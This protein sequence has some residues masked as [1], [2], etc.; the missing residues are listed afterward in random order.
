MADNKKVINTNLVESMTNS[1]LEFLITRQY[2]NYPR[3]WDVLDLVENANFDLTEVVLFKITEINN[4]SNPNMSLHLYNLYNVL[5]SLQAEQHNVVYLIKGS[6]DKTDIYFGLVSNENS[7]HNIDSTKE[8]ILLNTL[9]ANYPGLQVHNNRKLTPNDV[10]EEIGNFI[11]NSKYVSCLP[12]V[13]SLKREDPTGIFSQGI[14]RIIEAMNGKEYTLLAIAEPVLT[15]KVNELIGIMQNYAS[16][17]HGMVKSNTTTGESN[18]T[19]TATTGSLSA[20]IGAS[21]GIPIL[22][23]QG[24]VGGGVS[25]TRG[26]SRSTFYQNNIEILNKRAEYIETF[27]NKY[28]ERLQKGL[29]YGLWKTGIYLITN[30]IEDQMVGKNVMRSIY[31]GDNSYYEPLRSVELN[32]NA[33]T[34]LKNL[35][36]TR[37]SLLKGE[38]DVYNDDAL[39][40]F[41]DLLNASTTLMNTEELSIIMNMPRKEVRGLPVFSKAAYGRNSNAIVNDKRPT[42]ELGD[43]WHLGSVEGTQVSLDID[44]LTMHTFITGST[45][46]GKTNTIIKMLSYL[47]GLKP[48][49]PFLVIEPT[50][51]E[52]AKKIGGWA[53]V[54]V[55]GTNLSYHPLLRLNPLS[56]PAGIHVLEHIDRLTDILNACWPMYAAMPAIL[57]QALERTYQKMG[58]DLEYSINESTSNKFPNLFD[59]LLSLREVIK[60]SEYSADT[61]SDYTGALITRVQSLTNGL[62]GRILCGDDIDPG[63]MFNQNC[64]IDISRVGSIETKSLLMGIVFMKLNEYLISEERFSGELRHITVLEEA[65]HLLRKTSDVFSAESSNIQ[66]KAVEMITNAIAEMRAFGE[67]F[68]ISDQSPDLLDKAVIRNT[69]TKIILRLPEEMDKQL[70]GRSASLNEEQIHY[71]SKLDTGVACIYQN[72]WTQAVLCNIEEVK[73]EKFT[74]YEH[75]NPTSQTN[76]NR[77]KADLMKLIVH[78]TVPSVFQQELPTM[79]YQELRIWLEQYSLSGH[80]KKVLLDLIEMYSSKVEL[81]TLEVNE[82]TQL[83]HGLYNPSM[84]LSDKMP[85]INTKNADM[86]D[87]VQDYFQKAKSSVVNLVSMP[88]EFYQDRFFEILMIDVAQRHD[89]F[90]DLYSYHKDLS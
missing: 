78:L 58:W 9:K 22:S 44:K 61:K 77:M 82:V 65:H 83:I 68:I 31:S 6:K 62:N 57:K 16:E 3:V 17:I 15:N 75:K 36:N 35:K 29:S 19:F 56:F 10:E 21:I 7:D 69:N 2:A 63:K 74:K 43:L 80:Q 70:V 12:G 25:H 27:C 41:G 84:I 40:P 89:K 4:E 37:L 20:N 26:K 13:P 72:S 23:V 42:L 86:I 87:Q 90:R 18:S 85:E 33:L 50:K 53:G 28:I 11:K 67:G 79:D 47:Q 55:F 34:V 32:S 51:G 49:I 88:N 64:I 60:N 71:L 48:T 73:E 54:S 5:S 38:K 76:D 59:L 14:D 52:Y 30:H 81:N 45:G 66:G 39:N 1:S 46:A 24:G 8:D